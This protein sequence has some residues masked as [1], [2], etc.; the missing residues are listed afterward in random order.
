MEGKNVEDDSEFTPALSMNGST[1]CRDILN[2]ATNTISDK[3]VVGTNPKDRR[4][5][6]W[7]Y[8]DIPLQT[9]I[10][11]C[12][13]LKSFQKTKAITMFSEFIENVI[14]NHNEK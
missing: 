5:Q 12:N 8:N 7:K 10:E 9:V 2:S 13:L 11:L 1:V 3:S 14:S 4:N 6:F